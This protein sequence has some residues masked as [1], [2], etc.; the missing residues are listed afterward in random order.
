MT[1]SPIP[2]SSGARHSATSSVAIGAASD[3]ILDVAAGSAA[4]HNKLIALSTALKDEDL[5]Q[6]GVHY[7]SAVG[8]VMAKSLSNETLAALRCVATGGAGAVVLRGLSVV[9]D[10][11]RTPT[12]DATPPTHLWSPSALA[13][14]GLTQVMGLIPGSFLAEAG[15]HLFSH[16]RPSNVS[17]KSRSRSTDKCNMHTEIPHGAF[18][19]DK[20]AACQPPIPRGLMLAALKNP[21]LVPTTVITPDAA[22]NRLPDWAR[23]ALTKKTFGASAPKSFDQPVTVAR[24]N[25]IAEDPDLG[26]I[27]RFGSNYSSGDPVADAAFALLKGELMREENFRR[28][29]LQAG[30]VVFISNQKVLHGRET[31][32]PRFDGTDRWLVRLYG[33]SKKA[34][35]EPLPIGASRMFEGTNK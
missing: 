11:L 13:L 1:F 2:T 28:V 19:Q 10:D 14:L 22:I 17:E 26:P 15:Q 6:V 4:W 33:F 35:R 20:R 18:D 34:L 9:D 21:D 16:V 25:V 8:K 29:A 7:A 31:I 5:D 24:L 12:D 3:V 32:V 30:D 27:I 23:V